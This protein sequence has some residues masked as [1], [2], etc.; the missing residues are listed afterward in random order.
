[1]FIPG[2][3]YSRRELHKRYGGQRQGG[4]ST[5]ARYPFLLL[6]TGESGGTYGYKDGWTKAGAFQYTGE[7]QK[8]DMTFVRGNRAIRDHVKDGKDL[9]LFEQLKKGQ[10]RY[11][12][13]MSCIGHHDD[14]G[15]DIDGHERRTIVLNSSRPRSLLEF[16]MRQRRTQEPASTSSGSGPWSCRNSSGWLPTLEHVPSA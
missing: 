1:M 7:G 2:S 11:V 4:I 8:G 5:P 12:G 10:V 14:K 6:F 16:P 13:Q 3:T 15:P 9:H